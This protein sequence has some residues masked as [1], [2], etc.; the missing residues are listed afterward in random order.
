MKGKRFLAGLLTSLYLL[1]PL[2]ALAEEADVPKGQILVE[3]NTGTV[4]FAENEKEALPMASI[5]K[6]MGLILIG[7]AMERGDF[8][9][10]DVLTCSDYA[11]SMGGSEIWLKAGEQMTV[12]DLLK[13]VM[14][15]SANDAMVVFAEKIGATE[16]GFVQMMNQKAAEM[17]LEN[18]HFINATGFDEDGHY[19][20][21]ADVAK[22]AIE[23]QK[24]P[25]LLEY[26]TVWMDSLR[27]GETMLVNTNRLVRFYE[28][29]TGLKTGTTDAAGHC[30]CATAKRGDLA[31][32]S[33][34]LG[35]KTSDGR[36]EASKELLNHGFSN[37]CLYIPEAISP[38]PVKVV[39]GA[40]EQL[41][42]RAEL[43][44]GI[45]VS[46][47]EAQ[48]IR[49]DFPEIEMVQAPIEAGQTVAQVKIFSGEKEICVYD[50][51]AAESVE[52]LNFGKCLRLLWQSVASMEKNP[53][54]ESRI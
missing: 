22:M 4:L 19:T 2:S 52:E 20:C 29:T 18:S 36:F 42:L 44:A 49:M 48:N 3:M 8:S 31:L 28:G 7:E 37:Y 25:E 6:L 54:K 35:C 39:H 10:E 21:A 5:T 45:L 51:V 24:Y 9:K 11:K 50:I 1:Q 13:A 33:V 34:V 15:A 26:S 14:I 16:D 47:E 43:P 32:C 23:L 38:E 27:N 30:L 53:E 17:G 40:Q 46:R 41:Q 12:E